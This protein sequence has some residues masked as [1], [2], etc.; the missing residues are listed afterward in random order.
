MSP[1]NALAVTMTHGASIEEAL[2]V[3]PSML[4]AVRD[5]VPWLHAA[6]CEGDAVVLG[7]RQIRSRVVDEAACAQARVTVLR[8]ASTGPAVR[9]RGPCLAWTLALPHVASLVGDARPETLLNRNVRVLLKGLLAAGAKAAYFGREHLAVAHR[10]AVALG[11][12][13]LP[14]GRVLI[15]A[16]AG[17]RE[18]F[19]MEPTIAAA[20]ERD[21]DRWQGRTPVGLAAYVTDGATPA[22]VLETVVARAAERAGRV[23]VSRVAPAG[24]AIA[25]PAGESRTLREGVRVPIGW[26]D[27]CGGDAP[28]IGGDALTANV[29]MDEAAEALGAGREVPAWGVLE[30]ARVDDLAR[31]LGG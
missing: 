16:F 17:W 24:R 28:W 14:D 12:D 7:A 6:V 13:L 2:A 29:W 26:V 9:L 11:Y 18:G 30:G 5:G 25:E 23:A 8:R 27:A 21:T 22:S 4:E 3:A 10:P 19:A 1:A 15:E 20:R 31:A